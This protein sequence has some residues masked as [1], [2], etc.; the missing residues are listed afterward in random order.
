[1]RAR[2]L[3]LIAAFGCEEA[4]GNAPL[5]S[6]AGVASPAAAQDG[7]V[8][9]VSPSG[10]APAPGSMPANGA[11]GAATASAGRDAGAPGAVADATTPAGSNV[12]G[13]MAVATQTDSGAPG[14]LPTPSLTRERSVQPPASWTC[15]IAG[16]IAAI[17]AGEPV[18]SVAIKLGTTLDVGATPYGK[19]RILP[20]DG[21]SI[22]GARLTGTLRE[23]GL[24]YELTLA[25]GVVQVEQVA[26]LKSSAGDVVMRG[27]GLSTGATTPARMVLDFEA[28]SSGGNAWLNAGT[29]VGERTIDAD[30]TSMKLSVYR[31]ENAASASPPVVI[32][33]PKDAPAQPWEC[34]KPVGTPGDEL[35][36][37]D[38]GIDLTGSISVG[39]SKRGTRTMIPITGG[40]ATGSIRGSVLAGG[41]DYQ[42][43]R[44]DGGFELDARYTLRT[45]DGTLVIV[46]NCGLA[47][48]LVPRFE[49]RTDGPVAYLNTGAYHSDTPQVGLGSVHIVIRKSR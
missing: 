28:G 22:E 46:R 48:S 25:N 20:L 39:K 15:G 26:I 1:M 6:D 3:L 34:G 18:F 38:V 44:D 12:D 5:P 43:R 13:G 33:I 35:Y 42:L 41:G 23:G 8:A 2:L 40:T 37:S 30:G 4:S 49:T 29:Y 45:S 31:V 9:N 36:V 10:S 24:D 21:G 27:C 47:A 14:A 7:S 17:P 19:R 11:G 16:P 32:D